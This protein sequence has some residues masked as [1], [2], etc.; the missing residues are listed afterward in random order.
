MESKEEPKAERKAMTEEFM[1]DTKVLFPMENLPSE[2]LR[3]S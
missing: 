1:D 3:P 2:Y